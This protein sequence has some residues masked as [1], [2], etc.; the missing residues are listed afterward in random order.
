M[1]QRRPGHSSI[2]SAQVC[3][4]PYSTP[5]T[6]NKSDFHNSPGATSPSSGSFSG[7]SSQLAHAQ[8]SVLMVPKSSLRQSRVLRHLVAYCRPLAAL[9]LLGVRPCSLR[10]RPN[11]R[12]LHSKAPPNS[13][14]RRARPRA[15]LRDL[16]QAAPF[17]P[18]PL[19]R[20]PLRHPLLVFRVTRT[21]VKLLDC[22]PVSCLPSP[23]RSWFGNFALAHPGMPLFLFSLARLVKFV[24][25]LYAFIS[26]KIVRL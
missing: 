14:A 9:R 3:P 19:R 20:P 2:I 16:P 25:G 8:L 21:V 17:L 1:K 18:L 5:R 7:E 23:L 26:L 15:L 10:P 22:P 11:R 6:R 24:A 4:S 12:P 13:K